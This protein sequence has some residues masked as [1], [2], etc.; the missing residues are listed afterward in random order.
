[1]TAALYMLELTP[2]PAALLRFAQAQGL[3][4]STDEDMGY[5]T[6][7]WL[8]AMFGNLAPKPF[9][10]LQD[11]RLRRP[12][13]LLGYIGASGAELAEHAEAF[14]PPLAVAACDLS[15]LKQ[16]KAMPRQWSPGRRLGFELLVCPISRREDREKDVFLSRADRQPPESPPL[17]RDAVYRDW[18]QRQCDTAAHIEDMRLEGFR[19]VRMLRR[20]QRDTPEA[21][22]GT[23]RISRPQA[24]LSGT[25]TVGSAEGF[26]ALLRRGI[27]RHRAFGY[28]ML[29]LKPA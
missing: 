17:Q 14:A 7:A 3:N 20:G 21:R 28:G 8:V 25:L 5:A 18:L 15:Q 9:R 11:H 27:G 23:A 19:L 22:R 29:L 6:H 24:L 12:P 16:V 13:R 1:M 26:H 4:R 2:D 10:L